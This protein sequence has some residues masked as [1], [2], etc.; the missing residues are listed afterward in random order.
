[1]SEQTVT[2]SFEYDET[3]TVRRSFADV[4]ISATRYAE[5]LAQH[6]PSHVG[7]PASVI[8]DA[9][10]DGDLIPFLA[11]LAA[12]VGAE[13]VDGRT[14]VVYDMVSRPTHDAGDTFCDE[15]G[16]LLADHCEECEECE[17]DGEH[18]D[19]C[20]ERT[21]DCTCEDEED[22]EEDESEDD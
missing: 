20:G 22:D 4:T 9:W 16:G 11:A 6:A 18:C 8:D 12:E 15:H 21:D 13:P 7:S 10:S 19:E 5:L 14:E 3:T 1:M 17:C 2:F